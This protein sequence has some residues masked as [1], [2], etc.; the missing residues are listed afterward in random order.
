MGNTHCLFS[1]I[2]TSIFKFKDPRDS[3]Y[4]FQGP[5][6]RVSGGS[7][8]LPD[9]IHCPQLGNILIRTAAKSLLMA[10]VVICEKLITVLVRKLHPYDP[11]TLGAI[12]EHF[13]ESFGRRFCC[14][15]KHESSS[16]CVCGG[17]MCVY[18]CIFFLQVK[19]SQLVRFFSMNVSCFSSVSQAS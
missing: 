2:F 13:F 9:T 14:E 5:W 3:H 6:I 17:G 8:P 16:V 7:D 11:R 15:R 4:M 12:A 19:P 18:Y 10:G 1:R